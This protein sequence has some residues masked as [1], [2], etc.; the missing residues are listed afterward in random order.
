M[1]YQWSLVMLNNN[2]VFL[3]NLLLAQEKLLNVEGLYEEARAIGMEA[4]QLR[5]LFELGKASS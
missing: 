5:L 2:L 1:T 3:S 4:R